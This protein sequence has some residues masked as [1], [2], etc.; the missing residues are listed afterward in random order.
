MNLLF[1]HTAETFHFIENSKKRDEIQKWNIL[2]V[3]HVPEHI[4]AGIKCYLCKHPRANEML[5]FM[6]MTREKSQP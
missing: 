5:Y 2:G 6:Y 3:A 1:S 4:A